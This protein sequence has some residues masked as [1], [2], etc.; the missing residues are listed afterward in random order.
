[1]ESLST[2]LPYPLM[3]T[4]W[5]ATLNPLLRNPLNGISTLENIS[6]KTGENVINHLLGQVQQG[7][8]IVDIQGAATVFRSAPF[9]SKT[10]TLTASAPVIVSIGV[11]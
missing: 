4:K 11:Y 7:W 3:L 9:N 10:L 2:S 5:S 1:M 8:I 6:L